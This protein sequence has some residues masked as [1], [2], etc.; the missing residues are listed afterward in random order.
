MSDDHGLSCHKCNNENPKQARFCCDCGVSLINIECNQCNTINKLGSRYCTHC[1]QSLAAAIPEDTTHTQHIERRMLTILFCDLVGS[2]QLVEHLDPEDS[3]AFIRYYQSLSK[4]IIEDFGGRITEYLGDGIVAQFTRH[5]TNAE[6]AINASLDIIQALAD[7]PHTNNME[8]NPGVRC[9]IATGM[10]V[11]GDVLGDNQ[12]RSESAVGL[13]IN[14]AARIQNIANTNEVVVSETTHQFAHGLFDYKST[15]HHTLKGISQKQKVWRVLAKRSISSRFVAHAAELTPMVDRTEISAQLLDSWNIC[16]QGHSKAIILSGEAGIGKSRVVEEFIQK[17]SNQSEK[18]IYQCSPYHTNTALFPLLNSLEAAAKFKHTDNN[19]VRV[20]KL[21]RLMRSTSTNMDLDM[22]AFMNLLSLSSTTKR[23]LPNLD[24]DEIKE[25]IFQAVINNL[26]SLSKRSPLLIQVEDVHWIDPTTLEFIQRLD[27][28]LKGQPVLLLASA[29]PNL[30]EKS[31]DAPHFSWIEVKKLPEKYMREL[32]TLMQGKSKKLEPVMEKIIERTEGVPLF[33]EEL[34]KS[35]LETKALQ[36]GDS[37][38]SALAEQDVPATLHDSL[39]SRIDHLPDKSR[40]IALLASVIGREFSFN[41]LNR[42]SDIGKQNLYDLISPLLKAQLVLQYQPSPDAKFRFKHALVRDVTYKTLLQS[43]RAKIHLR[44][45]KALE[46]HYPDTVKTRPELLAQHFM[47]GNE[48]EKAIRYWLRA[49][50]NASQHFA[51]IEAREHLATGLE[52]IKKLPDNTNTKKMHLDLLITLGPVLIAHEG[53]GVLKTREN[54]AQAVQLSGTLPQSTQQFIALW[55]Q[56]LVL[57]DYKDDNGIVR[58]NNLEHLANKLED[59]SLKLQAHHCQWTTLFHHGNFKLASQH[60]Q[61]GLDNYDIKQHFNHASKF[62][63][64]DPKTC[65]HG[66]LAHTLWFLGDDVQATEEAKTCYDHALFLNHTGSILHAIELNL[67]LSQYRKDYANIE[68]W[69][70]QLE[71]ICKKIGLPEYDLKL[72]C[73]RGQV[74]IGKGQYDEG[75]SLI[76]QGLTESALVGTD[77]DTPFLTEILAEALQNVGR[78]EEATQYIDETITTLNTY[79]IR[80]WH[81]EIYRRKGELLLQTNKN[82]QA[83]KYF[84][85]SQVIAHKQNALTLQLR[86]AVSLWQFQQ[87]ST[88][89]YGQACNDIHNALSKIPSSNTSPEI[90]AAR[91]LL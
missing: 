59:A 9:G 79:S 67:L 12:I 15:G 64:H 42:I 86:T 72:L 87:V 76:E 38:N 77:E 20:K 1:G 8:S 17:I 91:T 11:V 56:W 35:L 74:L 50:Q 75:I 89:L 18:A 68:K 80:Y 30:T 39:L 6:R 31:L 46:A 22:P 27:K 55:G 73:C 3:R 57:M 90:K 23:P 7:S 78:I 36:Q 44:I 52:L 25:S 37:N 16:K 63:G 88:D 4:E 33:I 24:P 69:G 43:E 29:R 54:Y 84:K 83:L 26:I 81:A 47:L 65:G 28:A 5:E 32:I 85:K 34:S 10:A 58:A 82:E 62:G 51:L 71:E 45:A 61:H 14:L 48:T 19:Q 66:F 21:E 40:A 70:I 41:L 13:P 2:T 49:G 60:C 53:A